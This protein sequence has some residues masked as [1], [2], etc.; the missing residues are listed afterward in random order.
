[1]VF[2]LVMRV[3]VGFLLPLLCA[4]ALRGFELGAVTTGSSFSPPHP[5]VDPSPAPGPSLGC[6]CGGS[7][8][9]LFN[10]LGV[11]Q[12]WASQL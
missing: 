6:P 4:Q 3:R 1:M 2:L 10:R 5:S 11:Y 9:D 12:L 7:A 8:L